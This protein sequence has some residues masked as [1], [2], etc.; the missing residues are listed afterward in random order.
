MR[1]TS[2]MTKRA[3]VFFASFVTACGFLCLSGCGGGV[4]P[5][6]DDGSVTV[7]AAPQ[8]GSGASGFMK[9]GDCYTMTAV[10]EQ[11]NSANVDWTLAEGDAT[12]NGNLVC[13]VS[14]GLIQ[15]DARS[16]TAGTLRGDGKYTAIAKN[17]TITI[18]QVTDIP[19]GKVPY[20]YG[21]FAVDGSQLSGAT[22]LMT[23]SEANDYDGNDIPV[24]KYSFSSDL[25]FESPESFPLSAFTFDRQN[26]QGA[27]QPTIAFAADGTINLTFYAMHGETAIYHNFFTNFSKA[28][29]Q[30]IAP[31]VKFFDN[32]TNGQFN[33][34]MGI[35]PSGKILFMHR[36][37]ME[38]SLYYG[39]LSSKNPSPTITLLATSVPVVASGLPMLTDVTI[40]NV[41]TGNSFAG[42]LG[43]ASEATAKVLLGLYSLSGFS[44]GTDLYDDIAQKDFDLA[45]NPVTGQVY[46]ASIDSRLGGGVRFY[47]A[48]NSD[49]SAIEI[50]PNGGTLV[51]EVRRGSSMGGVQIAVYGWAPDSLYH[52][53]IYVSWIQDVGYDSCYAHKAEN[54]R[55][56]IYVTRS[57]DQGATWATPVLVSGGVT[58]RKFST[59]YCISRGFVMEVDPKGRPYISWFDDSTG[60]LQGYVARVE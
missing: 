32:T 2:N 43:G 36:D 14:E 4:S 53:A 19:A 49:G 7:A 51:Q 35:T 9:V 29:A 8:D 44:T 17:L 57:I 26:Y 1:D 37:G 59:N 50:T 45:V 46:A 18:K 16:P 31:Q 55:G 15:V 56:G 40:D 23:W 3:A 21:G 48:S 58:G 33:E 20:T 12:I 60:A 25:V 42:W 22:A 5:V 11:G 41:L 34:G 47:K 38:N 30:N 54:E 6:P 28:D 24:S 13:V 39:E 27:V 52:E 10:D